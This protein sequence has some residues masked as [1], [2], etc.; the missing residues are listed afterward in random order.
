[1]TNL[2]HFNIIKYYT[3][4]SARSLVPTVSGD[5]SKKKAKK[6]DVKGKP[7][8]KL[9]KTLRS[10]SIKLRGTCSKIC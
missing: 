4:R 8:T 2:P 10:L 1:M 7:S 5:E 3:D 9:P 6:E